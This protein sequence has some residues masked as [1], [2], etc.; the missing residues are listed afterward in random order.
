MTMP[1]PA[2]AILSERT[3]AAIAA[4]C[5]RLHGLPVHWLQADGRFLPPAP[6]DSP[7]ALPQLQSA[8]RDAL[9]ESCR[10]GETYVFFLCPSVI[11]W[12]VPLYNADERHGGLLSGLVILDESD[13]TEVERHLRSC[14]LSEE[15]ARAWAQQLPVWTNGRVRQASLRLYRDFYRHSGWI[16]S[17]LDRRREDAA[18]QRQVAEAIHTRKSTTHSRYPFDDERRLLSM[19]H[20]GDQRGARAAMNQLLAGLFVH[21]PSLPL[22]RA[23]SVELLGHLVR[24]AAD[25]N[26][27]LEPLIEQNRTWIERLVSAPSFD[28]LCGELREALDAFIVNVAT[29]GLHRDN[30]AVQKALEYLAAHYSGQVTLAEVAEAAGL[31]TFRTAHLVKEATGRSVMEHVRVMRVTKA[32][33][34][35]ESTERT[36]TDIATEL[37]YYDQSHFSKE[38]KAVTGTTP[39]H[40]RRQTRSAPLPSS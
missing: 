26:P 11:A 9:D 17:G 22:L 15:Q 33:E 10:W 40:Y 36:G 24:S 8:V 31:S 25:E 30:P 4:D 27:L 3:R 39:S 37:G 23:R 6:E 20:A 14:G 21:A 7:L 2:A 5:S 34:L 1:E 29:R 35:L 13:R 16:P 28:E 12:V 19:V 38:F 18:Q 32:R